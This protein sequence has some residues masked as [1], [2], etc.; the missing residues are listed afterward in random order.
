MVPSPLSLSRKCSGEEADRECAEDAP[1]MGIGSWWSMK[2]GEAAMMKK[3]K[4]I[5]RLI[6]SYCSR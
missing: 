2:I 3:V 1:L 5:E 6:P 4:Y